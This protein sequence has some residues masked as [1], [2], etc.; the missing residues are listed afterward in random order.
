[1]T[2]CNLQSICMHFS[3][4]VRDALLSATCT[5]LVVSDRQKQ[6]I[7]P[8]S[9]CH[10]HTDLQLTPL[11]C[12]VLVLVLGYTVRRFS[13]SKGGHVRAA[14]NEAVPGADSRL[15]PLRCDRL[16]YWTDAMLG[17]C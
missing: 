9:G 17:K 7:W 11:Q 2:E 12:Q 3:T 13:L 1:M 15:Q 4:A 5:L 6:P 16:G 14:F 10:Q 8:T